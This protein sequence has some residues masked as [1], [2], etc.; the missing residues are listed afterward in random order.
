MHFHFSRTAHIPEGQWSL[1]DV[2]ISFHS[3]YNR[4]IVIIRELMTSFS[5]IYSDGYGNIPSFY[6]GNVSFLLWL[7]H[8][9]SIWYHSVLLIDHSVKLCSAGINILQM[10]GLQADDDVPVCVSMLFFGW[11]IILFQWPSICILMVWGWAEGWP[12]CIDVL[13]LFYSGISDVGISYNGGK[14]AIVRHILI[15]DLQ[16]HPLLFVDSIERSYSG[17][18][19]MRVINE[20]IDIHSILFIRRSYR[21]LLEPERLV[22]WYSV[23]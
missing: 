20:S 19:V 13:L 16:C 12:I 11:L 15:W 14:Y 23:F 17:N 22:S 18:T 6:S 5:A 8:Y 1:V 2:L 3:P 9:Y 21:C 4:R 7:F 10:T